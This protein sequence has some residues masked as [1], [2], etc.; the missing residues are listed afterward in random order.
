MARDGPYRP[1][2]LPPRSL[3]VMEAQS[4]K[5][6]FSREESR[7]PSARALSPLATLRGQRHR[8]L[9]P[10]LVFGL[11]GGAFREAQ[12]PFSVLAPTSVTR[13]TRS[14][15]RRLAGRLPSRC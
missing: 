7:Q 1:S 14:R 3:T 4:R 8:R 9:A 15:L 2:P 6:R 12:M 5:E 13:E 10:A 11:I